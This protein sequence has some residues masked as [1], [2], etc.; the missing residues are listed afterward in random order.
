MEKKL[1]VV[2]TEVQMRAT[3]SLNKSVA[4]DLKKKDRDMEE[5][6]NEDTER[7]DR[8]TGDGHNSKCDPKTK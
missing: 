8:T 6:L 7:N 5:V 4:E 1:E 3:A 2:E